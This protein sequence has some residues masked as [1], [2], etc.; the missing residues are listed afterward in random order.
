MEAFRVKAYPLKYKH[1]SRIDLY[2]ISEFAGTDFDGSVWVAET[3][4][5]DDPIPF[6]LRGFGRVF[7]WIQLVSHDQ[8]S[9]PFNI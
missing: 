3:F 4:C 1:I 6:F 8:N 7:H 5:M 9:Q 2:F